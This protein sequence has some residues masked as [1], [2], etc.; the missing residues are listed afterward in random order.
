LYAALVEAAAADERSLNGEIIT[1]LREWL[2]TRKAK[3]KGVTYD[4]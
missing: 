1:A 2:R 4:E 3:R